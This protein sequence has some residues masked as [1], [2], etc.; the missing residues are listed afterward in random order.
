MTDPDYVR[1]RWALP[2][3]IWIAIDIKL[4]YHSGE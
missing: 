3:A 2:A 4:W 1:Q